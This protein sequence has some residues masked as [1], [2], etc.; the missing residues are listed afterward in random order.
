MDDIVTYLIMTC[1]YNTSVSAADNVT[2]RKGLHATF[3]FTF[4]VREG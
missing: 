4:K 1:N 2:H 3:T